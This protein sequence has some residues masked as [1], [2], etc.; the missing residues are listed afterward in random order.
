MNY[1]IGDKVTTKKKHACQGNEWEVIGVGVE[2]KLKCLTCGRE[3][4]M[5]KYE[6]DKKI[7]K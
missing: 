6:L 4:V 7:K 3:I 2:V 1:K 5:F